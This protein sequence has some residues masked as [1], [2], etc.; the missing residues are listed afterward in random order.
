MAR[1]PRVRLHQCG[2]R[3]GTPPTR[4]GHA[5]DFQERLRIVHAVR[6]ELQLHGHANWAALSR[7]LGRDG[8]VIKTIWQRS[9]GPGGTLRRRATG[10]RANSKPRL[11]M[12]EL[13]F[14]KARRS[15]PHAA[16][17]HAARAVCGPV[18][19]PGPGGLGAGA[20]GRRRRWRCNTALPPR[21]ARRAAPHP[22]PAGPVAHPA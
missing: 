19:T 17:P 21:E 12:Q 1:K 6:A 8:R 9:L 7:R 13:L 10:G 2:A 3:P 15:L 4:W 16:R 11:G 18:R 5:C 22:G 14:L 20:D